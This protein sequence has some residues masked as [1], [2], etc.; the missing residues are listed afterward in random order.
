[1]SK[2]ILFALWFFVPAGVANVMPILAAKIPGLR[3]WDAPVDGGSR[4][5]GK[6]VFDDHKTWR[7]IVTGVIAGILILKLQVN[8]YDQYA[9]ARDISGPLNYDKISV[10]GL[11]FLLGFGALFGDMIKSLAKRQFGVQPGSSW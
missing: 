5:R 6:R 3:H 7:G 11:G 1:M 9:W 4:L 10:L 2:D 8:L